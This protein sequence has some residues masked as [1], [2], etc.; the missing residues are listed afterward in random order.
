MSKADTTSKTLELDGAKIESVTR[1]M[2]FGVREGDPAPK[3]A[4]PIREH[5]ALPQV[6]PDHRH[7]ILNRKKDQ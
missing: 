1:V 6:R 5:A 7:E 2:R 3:Q 4:K